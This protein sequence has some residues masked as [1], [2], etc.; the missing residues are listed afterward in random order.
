MSHPPRPMKALVEVLSAAVD[1]LPSDESHL[2]DLGR[3]WGRSWAARRKRANGAAPRSRRGRAELLSR[4]LATWGWRPESH[5]DSDGIRLLTGRCLFHGEGPGLN[6]RC[7][8]LEEGLL[9][10]LVETFANGHAKVVRAQ[11]CRLEVVL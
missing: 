5:R 7:C 8:A 6:G 3:E 11:G 10:G 1:A 4:E 9:T 2:S